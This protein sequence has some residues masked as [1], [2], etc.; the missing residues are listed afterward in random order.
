MEKQ[1]KNKRTELTK[2]LLRDY[3]KNNQV[4]QKDQ[5]GFLY[6]VAADSIQDNTTLTQL[7]IA[8]R[9]QSDTFSDNTGRLQ[10]KM[11]DGTVILTYKNVQQKFEEA[12]LLMNTISDLIELTELSYR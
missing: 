3:M 6:E 12:M 4:L 8:I 5:A 10:Y 11:K 2:S 1:L 9:N 7:Y